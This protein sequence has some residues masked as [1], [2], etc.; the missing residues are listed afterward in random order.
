MLDETTPLSEISPAL[1]T[2]Q[3]LD[4]LRDELL[5]DSVETPEESQKL[6]ATPQ[7]IVGWFV[8]RVRIRWARVVWSRRL[9]LDEVLPKKK[10][11]R[12]P[13]ELYRELKA[14]FQERLKEDS[15]THIARA[16]WWQAHVAYSRANR[17]ERI[18]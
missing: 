10:I 6:S 3:T 11:T 5:P 17:P 15:S 4:D 12:L 18:R 16:R 7:R 2:T 9:K 14:E 8:S 13:F 1:E